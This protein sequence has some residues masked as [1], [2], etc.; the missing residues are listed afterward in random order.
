MTNILPFPISTEH[1]LALIRQATEVGRVLLP[2]PPV[3]GEWYRVVT[4]RQVAL[5][6]KEGA[7]ATAPEIDGYGNLACWLERF[8]AGLTVRLHLVLKKNQ[9]DEWEVLVIEVENQL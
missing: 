7:M 3:G 2:S 1:A 8:G 5:C 6:L 4:H 9:N